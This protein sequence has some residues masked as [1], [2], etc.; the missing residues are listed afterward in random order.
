MTAGPATS[1]DAAWV[2]L[3][4]RSSPGELIEFCQ[5][6]ER[7]FRINPWL[8]FDSWETASPDRFRAAMKNL[9]NSRS[10][11]Q[12]IKL[13]R[14]SPLSFRVI[15]S[16]G[17]KRSTSFEIATVPKGS[18]LTITDEYNVPGGTTQSERESEVDRSLH[19]W[20]VALRTYI[21]RNHRW[22]WLPGWQVYH[23]RIWLPMKPAS[24]RISK[25]IVLVTLAEFAFFLLVVT[26]F[27]L[28]QRR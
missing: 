17:I 2:T 13:Q 25:L 26:I 14:L 12:E 18:T 5:D 21:E 28:E 8:E 11:Q 15:Y 16:T 23:R 22:G 20:G 3:E 24:R 6:I 19:A 7:L 27:W 9:S 10:F 4:T 1:R